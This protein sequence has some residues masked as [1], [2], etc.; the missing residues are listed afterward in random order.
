[1]TK[2]NPQFLQA[3][4]VQGWEGS[5]CCNNNVC[6]I[7]LNH[8]DF[9]AFL[10]CMPGM[11]KHTRIRLFVAA[12]NNI[13]LANFMITEYKI[14]L[15]HYDRINCIHVSDSVHNEMEEF[16]LVLSIPYEVLP[17]FLVLLVP[18]THLLAP[19]PRFCLV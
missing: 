2:V 19:V 6:I 3:K 11:Y 5:Y 9:V 13:V 12:L 17:F 4:V 7:Y 15:S 10:Y 16:C 1:M 18:V 8:K 14:F